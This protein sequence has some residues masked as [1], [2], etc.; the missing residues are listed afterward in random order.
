MSTLSFRPG[1]MRFWFGVGL[2]GIGLL[3]AAMILAMSLTIDAP[4]PSMPGEMQRAALWL[5]LGFS[6]PAFVLIATSKRYVVDLERRRI[7]LLDG[8]ERELD[9][10]A[11]LLKRRSIR[12]VKLQNGATAEAPTNHWFLLP[13]SDSREDEWIRLEECS[14]R[15]ARRLL[16]ALRAA[17]LP[18]VEVDVEG[19]VSS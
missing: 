1:V 16:R 11:G 10:F 9:D 18:V 17:D 15:R 14:D 2:L 8:S 5:A 6:A 19:N 3:A 12:R 13:Q 7:R 4:R